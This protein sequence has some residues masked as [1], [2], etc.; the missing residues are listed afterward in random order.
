MSG[1]RLTRGRH[2]L[3]STPHGAQTSGLLRRGA[4]Q[5]RRSGCASVLNTT[6]S[7]CSALAGANSR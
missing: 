4:Y 7:N 5:V 6:R 3:P 1:W 2:A